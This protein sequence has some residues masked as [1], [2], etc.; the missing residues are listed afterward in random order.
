M[1]RFFRSRYLVIIKNNETTV[2]SFKKRVPLN[3]IRYA[4]NRGYENKYY[5]VFVYH[6]NTI[7]T[8][9]E[10]RGRVVLQS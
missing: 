10:A 4:M 5:G 1:S 9:N 6:T 2:R 8:S 7:D 3:L